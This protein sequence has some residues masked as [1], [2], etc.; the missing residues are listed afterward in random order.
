MGLALIFHPY[1]REDFRMSCEGLGEW[2]GQATWLM[3]FRQRQDRPSRFADY[4]VGTQRY[5]MKLKRRAWITTNNF[6]IVRIE[7]DLASP[8][9]QLAVQHQIAEY[10]PVR[11]REKKIASITT[12]CS[13]S[14]QRTRCRRARMDRTAR[15]YKTPDCGRVRFGGSPIVV[16]RG[17]AHNDCN[18]RRWVLLAAGVIVL[19]LRYVQV[20]GQISLPEPRTSPPAGACGWNLKGRIVILGGAKPRLLAGATRPRC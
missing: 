8:V 9:P 3:H 5:P 4:V 11:F 12:C 16:G 17:A 13:P 14:T 2:H 20:R 10:G 6:E 15:R 19:S 1:L 18:C 7:S